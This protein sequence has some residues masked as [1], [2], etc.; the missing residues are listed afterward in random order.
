[1]ENDFSFI[2]FGLLCYEIH[3]SQFKGTKRANRFFSSISNSKR[4]MKNATVN[5]KCSETHDIRFLLNFQSIFI[6]FF[7]F[8]PFCGHW[9]TFFE[10]HETYSISRREKK[11]FFL[12]THFMENNTDWRQDWFV[13][14]NRNEEEQEKFVFYFICC[15]FS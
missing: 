2:L 5:E 14:S 12:C 11:C 9:V 3:S 7:L 6:D 13:S 1:M 15:L 8:L 10:I 4:P